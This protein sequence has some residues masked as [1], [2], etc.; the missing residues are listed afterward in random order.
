MQLQ[1]NCKTRTIKHKLLKTATACKLYPPK[2]EPFKNQSVKQNV[3]PGDLPPDKTKQV[4]K[5]KTAQNKTKET[6]FLKESER[7]QRLP[8]TTC[9]GKKNKTGD[10]EI[11]I[12]I[13]L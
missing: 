10:L 8:P 5:F 7:K 13:M 6:Y 1:N 3:K 9:Q 2:H 12:K 11:I 4:F